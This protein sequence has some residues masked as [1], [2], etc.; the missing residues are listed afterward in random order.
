MFLR[1]LNGFSSPGFQEYVYTD[2]LNYCA[3]RWIIKRG[4]EISNFV[5]K[6]RHTLLEEEIVSDPSQV[7]GVLLDRDESTLANYYAE[8]IDNLM[9]AEISVYYEIER[10]PVQMSTLC[11][12]LLRG[13]AYRPVVEI[14]LNNGADVNKRNAKGWTP[15]F[16]AS[17]HSNNTEIIQVLLRANA[18]VHIPS[19]FGVT[20]LHI[21][22]Q[23]GCLDSVKLLI[24]ARADV[25]VSDNNGE[26]PLY[27]A[28]CHGHSAVVKVLLF[29][30]ADINRVAKDSGTSV[31]I[32]THQGME[33]VLHTLLAYSPD[34][35]K[36]DNNSH[37][38][39][40]RPCT[41]DMERLLWH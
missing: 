6:V 21:A 13:P 35:N 20:S 28:A 29:A 34:V 40:L 11:L 19:H 10:K 22:A 7:L 41:W 5:L 32:A 39:L 36:V 18:D 33:K 2:H 4:I 12:A 9:D 38:P 16:M 25:N 14:L 24:A 23:K 30:G 15:L 37:S 31:H 27:R 17:T 8:R 26:T 1:S 3:L